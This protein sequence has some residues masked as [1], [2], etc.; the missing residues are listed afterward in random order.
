[1]KLP[2]LKQRV[3]QAWERRCWYNQSVIQSELFQSE[4]RQYGDL[5]CKTTWIK[6]LTNFHALNIWDGCLDAHTLLT[7][8]FKFSPQRWDYEFRHQIID[9][10]LT[11]P[12][13]LEALRTG[14][15]QIL[16]EDINLNFSQ[17]E[18]ESVNELLA[19]VTKQSRETRHR[20]AI[21]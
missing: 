12:G 1:M 7:Q 4:M 14:F 13:A 21:S 18:K 2:E 20:T 16:E 8:H 19:M 5:R 10:F 9:E 11:L 17:Q 6:A 15:E 3:Y